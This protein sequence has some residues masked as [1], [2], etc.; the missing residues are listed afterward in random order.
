[1]H[2]RPWYTNP[3]DGAVTEI[4]IERSVDRTVIHTRTRHSGLLFENIFDRNAEL[5]ADV[6]VGRAVRGNTQ[7]HRV[8]VASI[9]ISLYYHLRNT[10]GDPAHPDNNKK[11]KAWLNDHENRHFRT[12]EGNI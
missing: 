3:L 10:L 4:A 1:M 11:W 12:A 7:K 2:W 5:K 9:P 6:H 8:R